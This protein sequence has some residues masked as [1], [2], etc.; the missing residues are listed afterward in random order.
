MRAVVLL[1]GGLDSTV[2]MLLARQNF[3]IVLALT[4]DYGQRAAAR[5]IEVSRLICQNQGIPHRVIHLPFMAE[6]GSGLMEASG[7]PITQPWVPN[8]NGI[9]LNLAAGFAEDLQAD[10]VVCGFN[11]EE[12]MD[13]PDNTREYI[14]AVN[15]ALEYSTQNRVKVISMVQSMDKIEITRQAYNM[16]LNLASLWSCYEGGTEPCG[17]CPSCLRNLEALRKAGIE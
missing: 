16:G 9:F 13:F 5:E 7:L 4:F 1:S 3:E 8:R 10:W 2:S 17:V 14:E 12:G 11:R 6:F 15:G